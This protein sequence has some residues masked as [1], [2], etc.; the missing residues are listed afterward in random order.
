MMKTGD[1]RSHRETVCKRDRPSS[2]TES[3]AKWNK[4]TVFS[5]MHRD[6]WLAD[7]LAG[8]PDKPSQ[9]TL[10]TLWLSSVCLLL[11]LAEPHLMCAMCCLRHTSTYNIFLRCLF[12]IPTLFARLHVIAVVNYLINWNVFWLVVIVVVGGVVAAA[13]A[14]AVA[15][16]GHS[17]AGACV[18]L[19]L[20]HYILA[21]NL[22]LAK[23]GEHAKWWT[24]IATNSHTHTRIHT[25][26]QERMKWLARLVR[27]IYIVYF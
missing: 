9:C 27:H 16:A 26:P 14:T 24:D 20:P 5:C 23:C 12:S 18:R 7:W 15:A 3:N 1:T 6:Y 25:H 4:K 11:L 2:E 19:F 13:A 17:I 8:W 21:F 10:H 22:R